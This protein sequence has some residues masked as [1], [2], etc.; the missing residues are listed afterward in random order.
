[1]PVSSESQEE[2]RAHKWFQLPSWD[3]AWALYLAIW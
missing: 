2:P 3:S 1:M